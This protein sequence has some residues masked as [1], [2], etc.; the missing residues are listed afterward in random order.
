MEYENEFTDK[1]VHIIRKN[2]NYLEDNFIKYARSK[3]KNNN[4]NISINE[5]EKWYYDDEFQLQMNNNNNINLINKIRDI[6]SKIDYLYVLIIA[7]YLGDFF[8]H[9]GI[10]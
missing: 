5:I 10:F 7:I 6:Q 1:C 3:I 2:Y 9:I 4:Y 8:N